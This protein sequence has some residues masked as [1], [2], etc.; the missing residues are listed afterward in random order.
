MNTPKKIFTINLYRIDGELMALAVGYNKRSDP[1]K[2]ARLFT[3][4][5]LKLAESRAAETET[6]LTV[7]VTAVENLKL[8][9]PQLAASVRKQTIE[10]IKKENGNGSTT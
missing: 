6:T 5:I 1:A 3:E 4:A 8:S 9:N 2:L 7:L 10:F